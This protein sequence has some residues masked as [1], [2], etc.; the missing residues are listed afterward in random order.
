MKNTQNTTT[1]SNDRQEQIFEQALRQQRQD[2]LLMYNLPIR[3]TAS[4]TTPE[5]TNQ[6]ESGAQSPRRP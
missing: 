2:A 4:E 3:N 5:N 6:N 1:P